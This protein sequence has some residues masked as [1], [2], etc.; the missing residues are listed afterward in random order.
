[1]HTRELRTIWS[2][3]ATTLFFSL[4]VFGIPAYAQVPHFEVGVKAGVPIN[5]PF[6]IDAGTI[7][8]AIYSYRKP[9][10]TFGPTFEFG[11]PYHLSVEA[12]LLY[13][14]LDYNAN[15]NP[16]FAPP[17]TVRT[18]VWEFPILL[19]AHMLSGPIQPFGDIG[20]NNRRVDPTA[21]YTSI[22]VEGPPQELYY[23]WSNGF[24]VGAGVDLGV[25]HLHV[26]PEIR[27]TRWNNNPFISFDGGF[28][29]NQN[30]LDFLFGVSF[31]N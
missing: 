26:L 14:R 2:T 4:L 5:N 19:K 27:Y 17:S 29:S 9:N 15:T 23:Y 31:G 28:F 10:N 11:L 1:M 30:E 12:D 20:M 6:V 8:S 24:T 7:S 21:N 22:G 13:R 18:N 25:S 3:L 16:E